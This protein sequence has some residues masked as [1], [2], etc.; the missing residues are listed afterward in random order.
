MPDAH[1]PDTEATL[2]ALTSHYVTA[3]E[4][5]VPWFFANMPEFYFRTHPPK[6]RLMHLK[7][8]VAGRFTGEART[9]VF[10]S[11]DG[12]RHTFISPGRWIKEF[13][14]VLAPF[15]HVC[16][17]C[18]QAMSS[19]DEGLRI[20]DLTT[21]PGLRVNPRGGDWRRA[22]AEIKRQKLVPDED[23]PAL[24][25]FLRSA[26][27]DYLARF[28][29]AR[30]LRHFEAS[31]RISR[32]EKVEVGLEQL[33]SGEERLT[34]YMASPPAAGIVPRLVRILARHAVDITRAYCD[35]FVSEDE[36]LLLCSFYVRCGEVCLSREP[37]R[38]KSVQDA[39]RM[40]KWRAPHALE[41]LIEEDGWSSERVEWL[42][43]MCE[44]AHQ[45]LVKRDLHAFTS[46]NIVR[47]VLA[48]RDAAALLAD[49]FAARFDPE[50]RE[51]EAEIARV[52]KRLTDLLGLE[53]N[54]TTRRI[55]EAMRSF[56]VRTLRTNAF[57]PGRLGLSFRLDPDFLDEPI[58]GQ[59]PY[60]V[61]FF[62][63]PHGLG[64]HIR[65]RDTAR[66][67]LRIV[68]TKSQARFELES[69]RLF[70]ECAALAR[71]QQD[72][73]KDIPEGGAKAVL[74]LGPQADPDVALRAMVD[75][76]LDL[77]LPEGE[78]PVRREVTDYLGS[79]EIIFLG[80]DE[81]ITP[82]R[83]A[84][85]VERAALR[86]YQWPQ[87]FMSSKSETGINH[88]QYA[89]T[90]R[91]V[92]VFLEALLRALG[93]DPERDP[94]SLK[95][96]GGPRGDV[97]SGVM[98]LMAERWPGTGRI[99]AVADGSGSACDMQ[100]LD[101]GEL[102]RLA[103]A[104]QSIAAFDPARL[105]GEGAWVRRADT[106]E[107]VRLRNTL[108]D[109]VPADVFLPAG[110]RPDTINVRNWRAFL[111]GE[112]RPSARGVVEGANI[113]LSDEARELLEENGVL[114]IPG[115]S[116]NKTGVICSSY[117]ILSGLAADEAD[118]R[119]VHAR[120]VRE[121][122]DIL[123]LRAGNE[124][125]ALFAEHRASGGRRTLSVISRQ[126]SEAVNGLADRLLAAQARGE[127]PLCDAKLVRDLVMEYC[128]EVLVE[129]FAQQL[130]ERVPEGHLLALAA[131]YAA[132]SL[133]YAEGPTWLERMTAVRDP[134]EVAAVWLAG[135]AEARE[136]LRSVRH[137]RLPGREALDEIVRSAG[138]KHLTMRGLGLG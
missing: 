55:I 64:F 57:V 122:M 24:S 83:I 75:S 136:L 107:G 118:L 80:P 59:W 21:G 2:A 63:V 120:F 39:L 70:D 82:E 31:R 95:M 23:M 20:I 25:A 77:L 130:M 134:A 28:E 3:A 44:F 78:A 13:L 12:T 60:G 116:A 98:K 67:G 99:V 84:W 114:I 119:S 52:E 115:A 32:R 19:A 68:P 11:P 43:A 51:R 48:R 104:E 30:V 29:A 50:L 53:D 101:M 46:E 71:T 90:S 131:H 126:I 135:R 138:L 87:A 34:V 26:G 1:V 40:A 127:G 9:V 27:P 94:F 102:L 18:L 79:R 16:I 35:R 110:G 22:M 41:E 112:G 89:V 38:L 109:V 108:H 72:K 14:N 92:V 15:E 113:F 37:E 123:M 128:P 105:R 49:L 121:V 47:A 10:S 137:S 132:A 5:V 124:A 103:A 62:H 36:T 96:T 33:P 129:R 125:A 4:E 73:N 8:V 91:G 93:I 17:E 85:I 81:N 69:N 6:D 58:A 74:L 65:F 61:Y 117:E 86:G 66:G 88:K 42:Q 76:F 7:A 133:V 54:D 111:D 45:T 97:A 56:I 100:G 106:P